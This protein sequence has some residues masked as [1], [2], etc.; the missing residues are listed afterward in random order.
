MS[1]PLNLV[2]EMADVLVISRVDCVEQKFACQV[3]MMF[4]IKGGAL[5]EFLRAPGSEFP[6]GPDGKPTF[7]PPAGWYLTQMGMPTALPGT[8]E[9]LEDNV[10][11]DGDDIVLQMR[12]NAEF[13]ESM[14]L[15][16]FPFDVQELQ[17]VVRCACR[18][19]GPLPVE[20]SVANSSVG[21]V[22][23]AGFQ[24]GHLYQLGEKA[25]NAATSPTVTVPVHAEYR[26]ASADRKVRAAQIQRTAD[27]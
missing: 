20:F 23:V 16:N 17:I 1:A 8:V 25:S 11:I 19:N 15:Q 22:Q 24:V 27:S 13:F 6:M 9:R 26:Q 18:S 12:F 2:L 21:R 7:K 10:R 4:R 3:L 5:D 14:E